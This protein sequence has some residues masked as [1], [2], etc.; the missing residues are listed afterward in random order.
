MARSDQKKGR[1]NKKP[2]QAESTKKVSKSA[3]SQSL[4]QSGAAMPLKIRGK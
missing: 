2:K 1:E 4:T 3:Y